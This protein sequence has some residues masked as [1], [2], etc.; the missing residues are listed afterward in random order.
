MANSDKSK[1]GSKSST[2]PAKAS[3]STQSKKPAGKKK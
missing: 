3:S 2:K 1:G